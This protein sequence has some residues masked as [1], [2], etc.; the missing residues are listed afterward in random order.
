[1]FAQGYSAAAIQA[2][3]SLAVQHAG[4][5]RDSLTSDA[6]NTAAVDDSRS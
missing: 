1:M 3:L 6:A 5:L 2:Q 4:G